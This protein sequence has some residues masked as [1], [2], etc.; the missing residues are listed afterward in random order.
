MFEFIEEIENHFE[1]WYPKEGCGV[2]GVTK[3]KLCWFPCNNVATNE[4]DFIID[5]KQYIDISRKTD[6][7]GI[8]HSHP[9]ADCT[10]SEADIKYC[11]ATNLIYYIFSYPGMELH[12]LKPQTE[13]K[14]LIGREYDFGKNDCFEL[15]RDYYIAEGFNIPHRPPFEDDWW[16]KDLDYF[17][18]DYI[19]TWNFK[20]VEGNFQKNDLLIFTIRANVGNHCAVYMG[21]DIMIHHGENRISCR[22]NI[23][24]FWKKYITG[25]YRYDA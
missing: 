3:G 18:D 1:E 24:P 2:L 20:K 6:I 10:P 14:P 15:A 9:D 25:V 8:V 16:H 21:N 23:Y 17:S 19:K 7:L 4:D 13:I 5:S 11:N 22:E 12:T